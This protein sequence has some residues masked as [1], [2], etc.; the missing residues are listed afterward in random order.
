MHNFGCQA[1]KQTIGLMRLK[2]TGTLCIT[3]QLKQSGVLWDTALPKKMPSVTSLPIHRPNAIHNRRYVTR[4]GT[5]SLSTLK[6]YFFRPDG[7]FNVNGSVRNFSDLQYS[8]Y[9]QL[10]RLQSYNPIQAI[11]H[12]E[13][14]L[15]WQLTPGVPPMHVILQSHKKRH[16]TRLQLV[17]LSL[18]DVFYLR[19]LL[20]NRPA[21]SFEDLQTVNGTT[22]QTFQEA[23]IALGL[24]SD[25][26]E[27]EYCFAEAIESLQT[28]Y[29]QGHSGPILITTPNERLYTVRLSRIPG[30]R[31]T[32]RIA[33]LSLV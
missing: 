10:F 8:E 23:C 2:S 15:E 20:Q 19:V 18:G 28:P 12:P 4:R 21:H 6:R 31:L 22:Y 24:F 33:W 16:V 17:R 25:E 3:H 9:F 5:G 30:N 7:S 29:C 14:L 1:M 27:V 32:K 11:K 13:W 26:T